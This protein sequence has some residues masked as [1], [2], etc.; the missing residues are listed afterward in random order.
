M[1]H[2][3]LGPPCV[4]AVV[5]RYIESVQYKTSSNT[6]MGM[7]RILSSTVERVKALIL[8][9]AG[10]TSDLKSGDLCYTGQRTC[11][12]VGN[13]CPLTPKSP[14]ATSPAASTPPAAKR[15]RPSTTSTSIDRKS[16]RLNSSHLV[17]SYA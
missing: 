10:P 14:S 1:G 9:S 8:R 17:I 4:L 2:Q 13:P 3:D 12:T 15:S 5:G 16:T 11:T 6:T 7:D